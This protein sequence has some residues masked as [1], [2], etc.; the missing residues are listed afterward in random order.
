MVELPFRPYGTMCSLLNSHCTHG[1]GK[2]NQPYVRQDVLSQRL[3]STVDNVRIP[4]EIVAQLLKEIEK[5]EASRE[6]RITER[7]AELQSELNEITRRRD[8][9]YIDKQ[10]QEITTKRWRELEKGW[11]QRIGLIEQQQ[12][13]LKDS[14]H[15]RGTDN[16]REAFELLERASELYSKQTPEE[17]AEGLK[18]LVS[19]CKLK[20]KKLEPIYKKPFDLVAEGLRTDNWYPRQDSN[21]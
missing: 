15:S 12:E 21:L 9:A 18:I 17:Q 10:D 11:T 6:E 7:L 1:K 19:I 13:R 20:G 5:G 4:E 3:Q 2:C 14:L 16:A 8:Q